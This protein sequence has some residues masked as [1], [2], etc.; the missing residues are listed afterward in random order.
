[1]D[2]S[3]DR[4]LGGRIGVRQPRDGFRSGTDAV[5][6][7]AA[8]PAGAGEEI[9]E[10]GSGVGIASLCLVARVPGCRIQGVEIAPELV[11]LA[12]GNAR[13]N[14]L[15][16]RVQFEHANAFA[17]PRPL[18]REF[19]HV[20]CN[21]PFHQSA[22]EVSPNADR[23]RALS[24]RE[25]LGRWIDAGLAR[26]TG[27]GT[28]TMILRADRLAEALRAAPQYGVC[29]FPLWPCV[30]EAAKRILLQI[31]KNSHAPLRLAAGLVLHDA[32]G[33]YTAQADAVLR[34][35]TSL[36]LASPRL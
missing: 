12:D 36:A 13:A 1:M 2:C 32:D 27:D 28:L 3:E 20:F 6:L 29:V 22:G 16:R 33:R 4:F 19:D 26:T 7:A 25:G 18:R 21:P 24:D 8:V 5:M 11:T 17:L 9:L 34:G 10:L 14:A 23:A 15:E 35:V 31:R 30:G